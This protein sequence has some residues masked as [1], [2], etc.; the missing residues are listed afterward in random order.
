MENQRM[1]WEEIVE[2]YPDTWVGLTDIDWEDSA[3]VRSAVV[4]FANEDA[5]KI[6]T[7]QIKNHDVVGMYTTTWNLY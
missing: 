1:T 2:K 7:E 4:A 6:L 5:N 3:N